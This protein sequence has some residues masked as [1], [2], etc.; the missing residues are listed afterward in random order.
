LP[1]LG[2][3]LGD[4][5]RDLLGGLARRSL[6]HG[7]L[8]GFLGRLLGGLLLCDFLSG[9][10]MALLV[11]GTCR[12]YCPVGN[13]PRVSD[14]RSTDDAH[15]ASCRIRCCLTRKTRSAARRGLHASMASGFCEGDNARV[16][17]DDHPGGGLSCI[18]RCRLGCTHSLLWPRVVVAKPNHGFFR[19]QHPSSPRWRRPPRIIAIAQAE[20]ATRE[21][22]AIDDGNGNTSNVAPEIACFKCFAH[23]TCTPRNARGNLRDLLRRDAAGRGIHVY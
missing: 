3:L 15:G 22:D 12:Y 21:R 1:G 10:V 8:G 11:S 23:S 17:H 7:L 4:L 5:L 6:A 14:P 13:A 2:D 9:H 16:H 19:C 20:S 18:A